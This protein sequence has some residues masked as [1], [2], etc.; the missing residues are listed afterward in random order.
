MP[1]SDE[2]LADRKEGSPNFGCWKASKKDKI[3]NVTEM[4]GASLV[5]RLHVQQATAEL[6][7]NQVSARCS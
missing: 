7:R 1:Q 3:I 5:T 6:A 2:A 4:T